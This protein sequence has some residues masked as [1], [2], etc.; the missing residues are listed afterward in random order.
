MLYRITYEGLVRQA[1]LEDLGGA[2]D[3]TTDSIVPAGT[4]GRGTIVAREA[5]TVAGLEIAREVFAQLDPSL[6]VQLQVKDGDQVVAGQPLLTLRGSARVILTGERV[7]L[8]LLARMCGIATATR[9]VASLIEGTRARVVCTRKTTPG[10]RALEKYAVRMGGGSNH[11]FGLDD[12]ILIKDNHV[13]VAGGV[14]RA[15][16]QARERAGHML[17]IEVEVDTLEQLNEALDCR[18]DAVLL[19]NMAPATLRKAVALVDG[20]VTTEA[21]G[22]IT[23]ENVR[24]VAETGVDLI[25][26]GS[27]THSVRQMDLSMEME[28]AVLV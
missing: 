17:K 7:A 1:L 18:I 20:R 5:G 22:G 21:S 15:V 11:R 25:S 3:V 10:L 28:A 19:D 13:A 6:D 24:A 27:L 9:R 2:G 12:A 23:L 4:L 14:R 8:N 26:M 16:E